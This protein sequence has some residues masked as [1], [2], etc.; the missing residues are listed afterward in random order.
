MQSH[1]N[2]NFKSPHLISIMM[3]CY[4]SLPSLPIS[5]GSLMCQSYTNW[6]LLFVDDGS[7]DGSAEFAESINDPRIRVFRF[8]KNLGRPYA[9]QKALSEARGEY[10]GMLDADDWYFSSKLLKQ[11]CYL[12]ENPDIGLVSSGMIIIDRFINTIRVN[13]C[14]YIPKQLL[15]S[16]TLF[17]KIPHAPT[18]IRTD[19]AKQYNYNL[20]MRRCQDLEFLSKLTTA[21]YYTSLPEP[22]YVY[23]SDAF[24]IKNDIIAY[25]CIN[26]LLSNRSDIDISDYFKYIAISWLRLYMKFAM[27]F[28]KIAKPIKLL[29]TKNEEISSDML[30]VLIDEF[31]RIK[32]VSFQMICD[33][34]H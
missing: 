21:S 22:L 33:Y 11:L 32:S 14:H 19:L 16:G 4:N 17:P 3:P 26:Y 12:E 29:L 18:L 34:R 9:R 27:Y 7:T 8:R 24:S 30:D 13:R 6:E 10:L 15:S 25:N 1:L 5:I 31:F 2:I 20:S 23:N 28:L